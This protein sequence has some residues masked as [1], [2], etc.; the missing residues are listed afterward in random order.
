M[1]KVEE[2]RLHARNFSQETKNGSRPTPHNRKSG[3]RRSVWA[4]VAINGI[5]PE[6]TTICTRP[7]GTHKTTRC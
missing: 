3:V 2:F 6:Q 4:S 1:E 7:P 5:R